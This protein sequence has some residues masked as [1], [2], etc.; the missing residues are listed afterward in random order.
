M[1]GSIGEAVNFLELEECSAGAVVE[2]LEKARR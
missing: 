2:Y 1:L